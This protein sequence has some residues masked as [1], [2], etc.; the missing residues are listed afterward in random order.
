L[1]AK[2]VKNKK[3]FFMS[4]SLRRALLSR[5]Y[6]PNLPDHFRSELVEDI[7]VMYLKRI[8]PNYLISFLSGSNQANPDFLIETREKPILFEV[9]SSKISVRQFKKSNI[10]YRY[11]LLVSNGIK[12]PTL[13]EDCIQIPLIWFLLL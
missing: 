1:D 11:G 2:I 6:G 4:P 5:L 12:K 8:L 9:G 3:A 13:Q 7:I 10:N